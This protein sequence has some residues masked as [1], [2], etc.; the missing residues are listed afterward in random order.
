MYTNKT[1]KDNQVD[2]GK[3]KSYSQVKSF[4]RLSNRDTETASVITAGGD[5]TSINKDIN[6]QYM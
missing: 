5:E 2:N 1:N 4:D 3:L 6:D